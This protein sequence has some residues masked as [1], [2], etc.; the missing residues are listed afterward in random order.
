MR[1][2]VPQF[3]EYESKIF[4]PFTFNQ[5]LFIAGAG[6][7]CFLLYFILP[8]PVFY[9]AAVFVIGGALAMSFIKVNGRPFIV[10][11]GSVLKFFIAPKMYIWKKKKQ[12]DKRYELKTKT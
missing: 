2:T 12:Q 4:G 5:F 1:F 8:R 6:G 10:A 3:I 7:I 9:I 11:L